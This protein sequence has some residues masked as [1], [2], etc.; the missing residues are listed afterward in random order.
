[1]VNAFFTY[2]FSSYHRPHALTKALLEPIYY[3]FIVKLSSYIFPLYGFLSNLP[4]LAAHNFP[5]KLKQRLN[6][7]VFQKNHKFNKYFIAIRNDLCYAEITKRVHAPHFPRS[8]RCTHPVRRQIFIQLY[9][10]GGHIP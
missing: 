6:S 9:D 5:P 2:L 7:V 8:V 1:M 3:P 4:F 10:N